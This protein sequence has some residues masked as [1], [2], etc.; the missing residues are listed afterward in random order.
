MFNGGQHAVAKRNSEIEAALPFAILGFD[1]DNGG[2]SLNWHLLNYFARRRHPVGFTRSRAYRKN[3]NARVEQKNWTHVRQL[4]GYGRLEHPQAAELLN[5]LYAKEWGAQE[6]YREH[7]G[8]ERAPVEGC[9]HEH[10]IEALT[11]MVAQPAASVVEHDLDARIGQQVGHH[12]IARDDLQVAL[13]D[14][15]HHQLVELWVVGDDFC[16]CAAGEPYH[17][18]ASGR[19]VK[20]AHRK[21]AEDAVDV[22]DEIDRH[23]SV[24]DAAVDDALMGDGGDAALGLDHM[25]EAFAVGHRAAIEEPLIKIRIKILWSRLAIALIP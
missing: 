6:L 20:G 1:T 21:R 11:A 23:A 13:I 17:Q 9:V 15:Y 8:G 22:V 24:V 19:R 5:E 2:E 25:I 12:R 7:V 4:V 18:D 10:D 14:L 3:D 16:P